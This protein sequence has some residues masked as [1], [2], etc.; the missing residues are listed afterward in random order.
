MALTLHLLVQDELAA[1]LAAAAAVGE[2]QTVLPVAFV[3]A[4]AAADAADTR[5]HT[6]QL[7]SVDTCKSERAAGAMQS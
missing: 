7:L 3:A 4:A 1:C 5:H 2:R 6:R